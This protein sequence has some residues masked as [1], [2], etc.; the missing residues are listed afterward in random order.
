MA[1]LPNLSGKMR[2]AYVLGGAGAATWGLF[3]VE[4][5]WARALFLVAGGAVIVEGLIGF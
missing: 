4:A 3:G 5:D 2:A 1:V